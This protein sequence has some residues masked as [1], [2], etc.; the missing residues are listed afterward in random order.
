MEMGMGKRI[1]WAA[2]CS[3]VMLAL[4]SVSAW[5]VPSVINFQG[6]NLLLHRPDCGVVVAVICIAVDFAVGDLPLGA[7]VEIE[8]IAAL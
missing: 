4:A 3:C 6:R 7:K 5:A 8:A 2:L 1:V